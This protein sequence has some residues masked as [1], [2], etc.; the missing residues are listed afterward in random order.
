MVTH[1]LIAPEPHAVEPQLVE[2]A[3]AR[4]PITPA[5]VHAPALVVGN[6]PIMEEAVQPQVAPRLPAHAVATFQQPLRGLHVR[7]AAG[8][9][10]AAAVPMAAAAPAPAVAA[11]VHPAAHTAPAVHPAAVR[12]AVARPIAAVAAVPMAV[13]VARTA[14][15]AVRAA[16]AVAAAAHREAV[17]AVVIDPDKLDVFTHALL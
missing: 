11:A 16:A 2:A 4:A 1:V 17:V 3:M 5:L 10:K 8:T 6:H 13:A 14:V 9:I 7:P 12:T 15:A